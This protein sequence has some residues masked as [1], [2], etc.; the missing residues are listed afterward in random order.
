MFFKNRI[1]FH[2]T[3]H[4]FEPSELLGWFLCQCVACC[5][6][7]I[8]SAESQHCHRKSSAVPSQIQLHHLLLLIQT[9][10]MSAPAPLAWHS[11][12]S[13]SNLRTNLHTPKNRRAGFSPH[14]HPPTHPPFECLLFVSTLLSLS[15]FSLAQ[16]DTVT[17]KFE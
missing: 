5:L 13:V 14:P 17:A 2:H 9:I 15:I 8:G 1:L 10:R 16:R 6:H 4:N 7:R 12:T 11:V 3:Q